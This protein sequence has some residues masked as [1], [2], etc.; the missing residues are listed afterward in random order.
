MVSK[1][2]PKGLGKTSGALTGLSEYWFIFLFSLSR[3]KDYQPVKVPSGAGF[4]D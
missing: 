2:L 4:M 1:A 3:V